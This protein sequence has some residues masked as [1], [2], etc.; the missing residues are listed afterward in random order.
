MALVK[1][2]SIL[3]LRDACDEVLKYTE[4]CYPFDQLE[5]IPFEVLEHRGTALEFVAVARRFAHAMKAILE[6]TY[7]AEGAQDE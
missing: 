7:A 2:E 3:E 4:P 5:W 6:E 1:P